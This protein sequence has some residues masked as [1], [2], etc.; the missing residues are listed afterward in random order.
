[1]ALAVSCH[2]SAITD[3]SPR[4]EVITSPCTNTWS[5]R[6]TSVFQALSDSSPTLARLSMACSSVPSPSRR[7]AKHS[8]PVFRMNMTRPVTPTTSPVWVSTGRSG[9]AARTSASVCVRGTSTGYGSVAAS[10]SRSRLS[11]RTRICSGRASSLLAC[12][13]ISLMRTCV[14]L[15][16]GE[17]GTGLPGRRR[18][19]DVLF[20]PVP[21]VDVAVVHQLQ[22]EQCQVRTVLRDQF[23]L[24]EH[25][26]GQPARGEHLDRAAAE[27]LR[28]AP[29]QAVHLAREAEQ[30]AGLQAFDR[31]LADHRPRRG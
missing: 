3:S 30:D 8:L 19:G 7:V 11:R 22:A 16:R 24:A 17:A 5:P 31:R 28:D 20:P 27:L 4:F 2:E 26:R 25:E 1:M 29:H 21:G 10:S 13:G 18:R 14:R 23:G 6:S 9:W 15:D 12:S